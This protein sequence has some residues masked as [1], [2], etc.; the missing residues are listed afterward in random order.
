MSISSRNGIFMQTRLVILFTGLL[1]GCQVADAQRGFVDFSRT[2]LDEEMR[3]GYGIEVADVD[4]DGLTDII[5]LATNPAQFVWYRNPTWQKYTLSTVAQ[6][7]IDAAPLDIDGDGDMDVVL[8]S[9]FALGESTQGGLVHWLENPGNPVLNQEWEMHYIDEIPTSHRVKWGDVNGDGMPELINLPII[10]VGAS[11]PLYDVDL[12]MKAYA[13]PPD[14]DVD[15]WP[16]LV[17]DESLQLAHGLALHD[18]DGNGQDDMLTASFGGVHLYRLAMQGQPVHKQQ[19]GAGKQDA[20]RP[21][22]GSSE[23][24]VGSL[25]GDR[26]IATVE[27]WHGNQ[28]VVYTEPAGANGLWNRRV[29]ETG[30]AN[31]HALLAADLNNDGLD[32]IIAGGRS[33]PYRL[34]IYRYLPESD[35]W[36][37]ID[38][39]DGN[40][41]VSGLAIADF[42]GDGFLDIAGIGAGTRNVVYYENSGL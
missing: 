29:I 1:S 28:V 10:G 34:A 41:A 11:A 20:E 39:D 19:L 4:G 22:I 30:L 26:F 31:G 33:E 3:G 12:Q 16:G 21:Q 35:D 38:L 7:N 8:A 37:R 27:P 36:R 9:E 14:L 25:D 23:V 24:D 17:L 18:F 42:N 40:I 5:A 32:E 13:I 2:T 15:G 6:R